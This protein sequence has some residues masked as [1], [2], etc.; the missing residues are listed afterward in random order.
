[1]PAHLLLLCLPGRVDQRSHPLVIVT[2]RLHEVYDVKTI[3]AVGSRVADFE[4]EPLSVA[5]C[6]VVI[7]KVQIVLIV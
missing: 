3:G 7:L 4:E 2:I 5:V 1:M 6:T